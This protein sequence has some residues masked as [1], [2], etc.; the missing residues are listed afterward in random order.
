[1]VK[2]KICGIKTLESARQAAEAGA[3]MLGFNFYPKSVR[4]IDVESCAKIT[5][6]IQKEYPS[7]QL[8]GVFVDMAAEQIEDV[9]ERCS[10]DL[11]QLSGNEKAV[12]CTRLH[13]R[14]Y[15]AF[16]GVP[17]H[18]VESYARLGAPA[19]LL[20]AA[21]HG[22]Y[23][24]TGVATDWAAA[25]ELAQRYPLLLAGGLTPGSVAE[26]VGKVKPWGVDVASGVES[27]P[28]VKDPARI[29]AFVAAVR[30]AELETM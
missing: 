27:E 3:D 6:A 22:A 21:V 12:L 14:S 2:I 1:M 7:T 13:G 5:H 17:G 19:L 29:R 4:F 25:G 20:D 24:G 8:V 16:H 26:A 23:C 11:A 9:L 15:K 10:L 30:A 28:G 18:E